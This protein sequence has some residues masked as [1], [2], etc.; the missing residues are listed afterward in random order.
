MIVEIIH[1][2]FSAMGVS[3]SYSKQ[4]GWTV[5]W[6]KERREGKDG[7][8]ESGDVEIIMAQKGNPK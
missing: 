4:L 1:K 8:Q 7:G 5:S 2:Q 3:W 6:G